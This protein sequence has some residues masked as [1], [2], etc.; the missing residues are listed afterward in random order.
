[1]AQTNTSNI[2][3]K[4]NGAALFAQVQKASGTMR[5][6]VGA[7]PT[8]MDV[9]GKLGKQQ[10]SPGMSIVELTDLTK[11]A[12][13]S[14]SIDCIDISTQKPIMGDKQAEGKGV[15]LSFT[16][17]DVAIN[18]WTFPVSAGGRMAQQRVIHDLRKM[19]RATA[20]GLASRYY[21]QRTLVH[22]AGARGSVNT[23]DW[24]V[25]LASDTEFNDIM[26]NPVRAPTFNRH[27]V[28][29]GTSIVQGGQQLGAIAS[30]DTLKLT[31]L[32]Q[33][34]NV[35]D[36][37]D[38]SIQSV[39]IA[40]DPAANDDPMWVMLAPSN[41]YSSLLQEGSLRA[42]QQHAN[43]RAAY[44]SKHPLFR[45]EVGMWNGILVKKIQRT[46]RFAASETVQILT[47]ANAATEGAT[48]TGQVVNAGIGAGFAVERC[49]LLGA[50][51]LVNAYGKDSKSGT[52]YSWA[53]KYQ[54]FEREPEFAVFGIEGSAKI[55]FRVPDGAGGRVWTDHGA[56][57][58]DVAARQSV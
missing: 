44:G 5:S 9:E 6:M 54:N 3:A 10:S 25:P 57:I 19:A 11:T 50:Q 14:A 34:R 2:Q 15:P 48:E 27:Y 42:F 38:L 24:I 8:E 31:H 52:H 18:Q 56:M 7:K 17:M 45:G 4:V 12:G 30:T 21:E 39:K 41:V 33:L 51:A 26:T 36:N 58:L 40:D 28:V 35:I 29:S 37:L 49:V 23:Q 16:S 32:D 53:E 55:R 22:L 43:N 13:G 47:A 1:M 46:I 20:V